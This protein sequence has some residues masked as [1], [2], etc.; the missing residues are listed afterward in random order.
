M[1]LRLSALAAMTALMSTT[2]PFSASAADSSSTG[3]CGTI[4]KACL[5]AGFIKGDWGKGKGLWYDCVDPIFQGQEK[6][7]DLLLPLPKV[8]TSVVA[9]C[10]KQD[11]KFGYKRVGSEPA[12][13]AKSAPSKTPAATTSASGIPLRAALT[14]KDLLFPDLSMFRLVSNWDDLAKTSHGIVGL[15]AWESGMNRTLT[16]ETLAN[17]QENLRQAEA[18]KMIIIGYA[19]GVGGSGAA[20]A[21]ALLALFHMGTPGHPAPGH[22]LALDFES[23]PGG[24]SMTEAEATDFINRVHERTGRYPILYASEDYTSRP[25]VLG[26]CPRWVAAYGPLP[27]NA[28]IWQYTDGVLGPGPHSFPGVGSCDI[29]KLLVTYGALREMV[30]L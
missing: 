12:A 18:R 22:I 8:A 11:P 14:Q 3:A 5:D 30:G 25:G 28:A 27:S 6:V 29:N 7:A 15:K 20:Q 26:K 1:T 23:N 2:A 9:A 24:P 17:F 4:E 13:S 21:D 16:Q 10:R 19:F